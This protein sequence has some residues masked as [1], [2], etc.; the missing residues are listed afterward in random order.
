VQS[1]LA[2]RLQVS[3]LPE[4][5]LSEL[6][7]EKNKD[8]KT[9]VEYAIL[10]MREQS[11][12]LDPIEK[13]NPYANYSK[14]SEPFRK[15]VAELPGKRPEELG[16]AVTALWAQTTTNKTTPEDRFALLHEA[17]PLAAR[18]GETLAVE[19]LS[20]VPEVLDSITPTTMAGND[21][22]RKSAFVFERALFLAAHFGRADLMA[23]LTDSFLDKV[24]T[25]QNENKYEMVS[26]VVSQ[27]LRG[28]KKLGM[29][30]AALALLS[31]LQ[32]AILPDQSI[33]KLRENT[34]ARPKL[35]AE[36]LRASLHIAGGWCGV[37]RPDLAEPV[38]MQA[39]AELLPPAPT[40][41]DVIPLVN[42]IRAYVSALGQST[43]A[44]GLP[45]LL[46]LFTK[47]NP[48]TVPVTFTTA[49]FFSRHHLNLA[50]DVVFALTGDDY[51]LSD[52]G[53]YWRDE[54]ERVV[55]ERIHRDTHAALLAAGLAP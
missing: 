19:L 1:A 13:V 52:S 4:D 20:K 17:L 28:M 43:A 42:L 3:S 9:I 16:R 2:G 22:G 39:R 46:D 24:R 32:N 33:L 7:S 6:Q 34:I 11:R 5:W 36:A 48:A 31:A 51:A 29:A 15:L 45:R 30:D 37:G 41:F 12:V 54:E 25:Q 14:H 40:K 44:E 26:A 50:E 55:R 8:S 10:R 23:K 18:V 53:R 21:W 35:W 27:G 38:F 47:L 49:R